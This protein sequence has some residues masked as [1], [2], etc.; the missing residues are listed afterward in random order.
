MKHCCLVN[1]ID[2]F[3]N[4]WYSFKYLYAKLNIH[5]IFADYKKQY[6]DATDLGKLVYYYFIILK[7]HIKYFVNT[8][9]IIL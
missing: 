1:F 7:S 6:D 4:L 2:Y 3:V 5:V 9:V 8:F